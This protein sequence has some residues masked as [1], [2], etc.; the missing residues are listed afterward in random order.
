MITVYLRTGEKVEVFTA[1]AVQKSAVTGTKGIICY[2][3]TGTE[4]ARFNGPDM[5]GYAQ[6][7]LSFSLRSEYWGEKLT[8]SPTPCRGGSRA[9]P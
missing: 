5:L 2:D 9:E 4:V 8:A 6:R 1:T 3:P 7:R